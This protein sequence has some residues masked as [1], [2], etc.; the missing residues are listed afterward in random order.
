MTER[1]SAEQGP[2]LPQEHLKD[3]LF[4]GVSSFLD[5]RTKNLSH[6][7]PYIR[8]PEQVHRES[9]YLKPKLEDI[10]TERLNRSLELRSPEIREARS[11]VAS[12]L[13]GELAIIDCVDGRMPPSVMFGFTLGMVKGY[14]TPAGNP[15]GFQKDPVTKEEVLPDDTLFARRL[16]KH[17]DGSL[18][19]FEALGSHLTCA[20]QGRVESLTGRTPD[21]HGLYMNVS[22]KRQKADVIQDEFYITTIQYSFDPRTGYSYWGLEKDSNLAQGAEIGN[23]YTEEL[24]KELS[25]PQVENG[26]LVSSPHVVSTEFIAEIFEDVFRAHAF[27]IDWAGCYK[28]SARDFWRSMNA[29]QDNVIPAVEEMVKRLYEGTGLE[30]SEDETRMRA[31][32]MTSNAFNAWL[33]VRDGNTF[34]FDTHDE[35]LVV[36]DWKSKGPFNEDPALVSAPE[37]RTIARNFE[38]TQS[39]V[40]NNRRVSPGDPD[41]RSVTDPTGT[42]EP[43]SNE[44]IQAPVITLYKEEIDIE[45]NE[46]EAWEQ[47]RAIDWNATVRCEDG[48]A[49]PMKDAWKYVSDDHFTV[50]LG[51]QLEDGAISPDQFMRIS[52]V[53]NNMRD[54]Y[55]TLLADDLCNRL[56]VNGDAPIVPLLVSSDRQPQ[57]IVP[58]T[59]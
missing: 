16:R 49:L 20:A 31:I 9:D 4:R 24:L 18:E 50:W 26:E 48:R 7:P 5:D 44:W 25:A 17:A 37:K 21:D 29:M 2:A 12:M 41:G 55:K 38:L 56:I 51:T 28:E 53:L 8:T 52:S 47:I 27:D 54:V 22:D 34:P 46:K 36:M 13:P 40:R 19:A 43:G 1:L 15:D 39:I 33:H 23:Q 45:H 59:A 6:L 30:L 10:L 35:S 42:Y 14:R 57:T 3:H 32:M 58:F 11:I